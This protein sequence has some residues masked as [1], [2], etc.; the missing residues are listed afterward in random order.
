[1]G[2]EFSSARVYFRMR[3]TVNMVSVLFCVAGVWASQVETTK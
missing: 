3:R 2:F 1:M